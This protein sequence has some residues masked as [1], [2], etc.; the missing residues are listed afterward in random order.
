MKSGLPCQYACKQKHPF[1]P[2]CHDSMKLI[3]KDLRDMPHNCCSVHPAAH[4]GI[5]HM[6]YNA[7]K[8]E[9]ISDRQVQSRGRAGQAER[10]QGSASGCTQKHNFRHFLRSLPLRSRGCDWSPSCSRSRCWQASLPHHAHGTFPSVCLLSVPIRMLAVS[11]TGDS[12]SVMTACCVP[13]AYF[14]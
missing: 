1:L 8:A 2:V 7:S 12:G 6:I 11:K 5:C 4:A 9:A 3:K 13:R 10:A 14:P